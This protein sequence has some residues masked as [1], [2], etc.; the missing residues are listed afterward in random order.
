MGV[1]AAVHAAPASAGVSANRASLERA[2]SEYERTQSRLSSINARVAA[3]SAHLDELVAQQE[4]AQDRLGSRARNM[5]RSGQL[6]LLEVITSSVSFEEFAAN[7]AILTRINRRDADAIKDLKRARK[8]AARSAR[9]LEVLQAQAA[10]QLRSLARQ[11]A[12][13][14]RQ[15]AASQADYAEYLRRIAAAEERTPARPRAPRNSASNRHGSGAWLTGVAS[16]Y[17]ANFSGR[18]ASGEHIGPDSMIVAH[19]TLPFGTLVEIKYNGRRA[20]AHVADRGPYTKGRVL[21]LGP[22]VI[23]VLG[24]SG[25]HKVQYRVIGR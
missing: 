13:A 3:S 6:S 16:H 12:A 10:S 21:D 20:V 9:D 14:K 5:Y 1:P 19:K 22:G 8:E 7:W 23:R 11:R 15:L 4:A 25:V 18:G 2:V 24:F 17:G